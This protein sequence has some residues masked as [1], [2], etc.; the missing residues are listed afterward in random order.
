MPHVDYATELKT[1]T[2]QQTTL[3]AWRGQVMLIVNVA[4][5]CGLTP[6]YEA[7]EQLYRRFKGKGFVVLGLPC[8]QFLGQE[9]GSEAEIAHYCATTWDITFPLLAKIEVNGPQRHPL[10][11]QLIHAQPHATAEP[12]SDFYQRMVSKGRAPVQAGDVL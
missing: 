2:G 9:P 6:Q 12:E 1:I 11:Q 3:A 10:Y 4:S 5:Q 8:N 7:L